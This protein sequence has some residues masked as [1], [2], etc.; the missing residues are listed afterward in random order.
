MVQRGFPLANDD[1]TVAEWEAMAKYWM[2]NGVIY[3]YL[4][5]AEPFGDSSGRQ[6][7]VRTGGA[8]V[9]GHYW[10]SDATV[11]LALSA[12]S[13]GNPRRDLIVVRLDQSVS[14][15]TLALAVVTGT[16]AG[17]PSTP[18]VTYSSTVKE[19][20]LGY[21]TVADGA[22]TIA[23]GDVVD[24]RAWARPRGQG[25]MGKLG[26]GSG[27]FTG[28]GIASN[29]HPATGR[30][31]VVWTEAFDADYAIT[32]TAV[33]G[34]PLAATVYTQSTT[35]AEIRVYNTTTG[36][37]ADATYVSIHARRGDI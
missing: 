25:V 26:N 9:E 7:K 19:L 1:V 11:T 8:F 31:T 15:A 35:G 2:P 33:T 37:L 14:P 21:A 5:D 13:S 30:Y 16:P 36:A 34:S 3:G 23:S 6:V 12:N 20:A 27:A 22:T 29:D 28:V 24:L 18:S 4:L 17:S 32:A 10:D